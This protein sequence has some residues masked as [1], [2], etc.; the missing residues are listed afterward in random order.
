MISSSRLTQNLSIVR[1]KIQ[2][3]AQQT[4]RK[5]KD[6]KIVA[7]TKAFPPEILNLAINNNL[8]T[9][10]ESRI[11]EVEKKL[12]IFKYRNKIELHLIGHLQRN[13]VRKAVNYFDIIQTV[14][15]IKLIEQINQIAKKQ[16]KTQKIFIQVNISKDPNKFGFSEK[17]ILKAAEKTTELNNIILKGIM[18]IPHQYP[19]E[20]QLRKMY[21]KTRK[22]RNHIQKNI[23]NKCISLSI[24]M[25]ND[26]EIA[27]REGATHIRIGTALFGE[28]P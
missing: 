20:T 24:G 21:E 18:T 2:H 7:V 9:I 11:Q 15:S 8:I 6:I 3:S 13:K 23:Q 26:Y 28:R 14:D 10:G 19:S 27:I 16:N 17:N 25:S 4:G 12:K 1:S 5:I 22:I